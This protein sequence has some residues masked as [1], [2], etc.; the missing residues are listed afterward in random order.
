MLV[1]LKNGSSGDEAELMKSD[2]KKRG[3]TNIT[4]ILEMK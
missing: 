4:G 1:F 3:T 2:E